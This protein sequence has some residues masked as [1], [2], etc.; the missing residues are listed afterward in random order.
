MVTLHQLRCFLATVEHGSFTAAAIELGYAQPSVSEQ[1]RLL[2][3]H[4]GAPLFRRAGRGLVPT[5]EAAALRPHAAAALANV[6][7]ATRAVAS[8]R[9]A[10]TGTV[11][12]GIFRT[13]RFYLGAELVADVLA[14]H[15]G[16]RLEL[17]GQNSAD[18]LAQM[19]K[20]GLEAALIALPVA[21]EGLAVR[22]VMRDELVYVS[23]NP[24]RLRRPVTPADLAAAPLV[25]PDVS[26]REEDSTR[27]MIAHSV[28]SAGLSLRPRVEVEDTE[29]ALEIAATGLADTITW[30]GVLHKLADR[31]PPALGSVRLRP[32]LYETFAIVH[33][34]AAQLSLASRAVV[35]IAAARMGA[36]DTALKQS[37]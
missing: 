16:V 23:A 12:F 24:D 6:D 22:P 34:P 35:E 26:W 21:D 18:V 15:P 7:E 19:R 3:Q 13:S 9:Q 20:G 25:L 30:R 32:R 5:E 36:L 31:L 4:L 33:R 29:T 17:A 27:R 8:V 14:R 11:R 1:V 37:S 2:E 28:Q 10:L